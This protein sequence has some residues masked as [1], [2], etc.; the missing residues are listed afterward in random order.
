MILTDPFN[1]PTYNEMGHLYWETGRLSEAEEHYK[2]GILADSIFINTYTSLASLFIEMN[3]FA[4]AEQVCKRSI[5]MDSTKT[6][7]F[8]LL[9]VV[10]TRLKRYDEAE[11]YGKKAIEVDPSAESYFV[12]SCILSLSNQAGKAFEALEQTLKIGYDY[13]T[14]QND[15]ELAPLHKLPKW[16]ELME[17]YFPDKV[18]D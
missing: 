18:K 1:A 9:G 8:L 7:G 11:F 16:K 13:D 5:Q 15:P 10:Y 6:W 12:F 17:K 3:R 4:E 14:I 2:K